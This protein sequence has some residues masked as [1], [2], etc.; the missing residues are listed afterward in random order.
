MIALQRTR[1]LSAGN[2]Q[3]RLRF[4]NQHTQTHAAKEV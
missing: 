3:T 2:W 1:G 4:P